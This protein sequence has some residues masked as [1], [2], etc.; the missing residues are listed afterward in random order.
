VITMMMIGLGS[1]RGWGG[2]NQW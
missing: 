1:E 2:E